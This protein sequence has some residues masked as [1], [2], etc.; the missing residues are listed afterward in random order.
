[1][2]AKKAG[3]AAARQLDP[4]SELVAAIDAD[5]GDANWQQVKRLYAAPVQPRRLDFGD[6]T[7]ATLD[8]ALNVAASSAGLSFDD[9]VRPLLGARC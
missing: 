5:Y 6:I 9:D 7:P 3:A 4:G 1:M 2:A 8:G